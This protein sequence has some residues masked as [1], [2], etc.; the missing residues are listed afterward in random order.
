[1][2]KEKKL[3]DN[4]QP[5]KYSIERLLIMENE[6]G[7]FEI[8]NKPDWVPPN[9]KYDSKSFY[10]KAF[11]KIEFGDSCVWLRAKD[12]QPTTKRVVFFQRNQKYVHSMLKKL[13]NT[14]KQN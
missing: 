3:G 13:L 2:L 4:R 9:V 11:P 5:K 14:V 7:Y 1:M 8:P 6:H 10:D 12:I